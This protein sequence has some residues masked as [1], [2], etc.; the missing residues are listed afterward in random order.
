MLDHLVYVVAALC[1]LS[2]AA[3]SRGAEVVLRGKLVQKVG[4][5]RTPSPLVGV[6]IN[7]HRVLMFVDT[8][9]S[10][11]VVSAAAVGR[12]GLRRGAVVKGTD[13]GN[14]KL[15]AF[16]IGDVLAKIGGHEVRLRDVKGVKLA[17]MFERLGVGGFISPQRLARVGFVGLDFPRQ[18]MVLLRGTPEQAKRWVE[19]RA[20]ASAVALRRLRGPSNDLLYVAAALC[21]KKPT[22]A[23]VDTGGSKTE[24]TAGYSQQRAPT[25]APS[26]GS[27]GA[28]GRTYAGRV[29][30]GQS[31]CFAGQRHAPLALVVR[32]TIDK[33]AGAQRIGLLLGFNVLGQYVLAIGSDRAQP[34]LFA[35]SRSS[36]G[37]AK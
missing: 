17:P 30:R 15:N 24:A 14:H 2:C 3:R 13:H 23:F 9:A 33:G 26:K 28:S 20:A 35:R 5:R 1:C 22:V 36:R 10:H 37:S 29:A 16:E 21:K 11:H 6:T 34:L 8:G 27:F 4:G 18:E 25:S 32:P 19:R 31:L 12:L 7:G